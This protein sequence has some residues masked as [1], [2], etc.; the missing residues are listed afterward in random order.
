MIMSP[1]KTAEPVEIAFGIWTQVGPKK[2]Y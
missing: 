1:A 2:L